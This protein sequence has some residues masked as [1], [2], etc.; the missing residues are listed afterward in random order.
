[1]HIVQKYIKLYWS[2]RWNILS[3]EKVDKLEKI[4]ATKSLINYEETFED[5]IEVSKYK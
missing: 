2:W 5:Y 1:M 4:I 3:N